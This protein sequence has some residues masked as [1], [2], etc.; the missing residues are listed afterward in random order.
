MGC[1]CLQYTVTPSIDPWYRDNP[2]ACPRHLAT[3]CVATHATAPRS[4]F[5]TRQCSASHGKGVTRLSSHCSTHPW[6]ARSPD[7]SPIEH[8]L[9][10]LDGELGI[11]RV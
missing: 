3:T 11:P 8:I 7:L 5:S 9:N 4:H 1:H 10:H 2:A 6:P